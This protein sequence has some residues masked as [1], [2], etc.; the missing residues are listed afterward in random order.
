MRIRVRC[1]GRNLD[2]SLRSYASRRLLF[3][4]SRFGLTAATVRFESLRSHA[5]GS[6]VQCRL[7]VELSTSQA[8]TAEVFDKEPKVAF[9]RALER[10]RRSV[11]L[12]TEAIPPGG[13][14]V[15]PVNG[16]LSTLPRMGSWRSSTRT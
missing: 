9:D 2:D 5:V 16:R 8:A 3:A 7:D 13:A 14:A 15:G 6:A 1:G 10:V 11:S 4:L 12:L